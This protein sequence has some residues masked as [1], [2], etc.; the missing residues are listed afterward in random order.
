MKEIKDI[1]EKIASRPEA[2][3]R[4]LNTLSLLEYIG[5]RKIGKTFSKAHPS[6]D[7]LQH[8]SDE[9]RHA[10]AFKRLAVIVSGGADAG[11]L[12]PDEAVDYFQTLDKT[13]TEWISKLTSKI[14][15]YQNYLLVT[16]V[17]ERRAMKLYPLYRKITRNGF[18][19]DELKQVVE[20]ETSHRRMIEEDCLKI[21]NR[22]DVPDFEECDKVEEDLFAKFQAAVAS[23]IFR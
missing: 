14:D 23:A 15:S 16:A 9:T 12:C 4:W 11:Y 7:I 6:L 2:E 1:L 19:R 3:A 13:L 18:V 5:A 22:N 20:E 10:Y 8:H 21:L 17:V